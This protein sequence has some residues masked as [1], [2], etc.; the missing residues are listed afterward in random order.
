MWGVP[1][2]RSESRDP[3][4]MWGPKRAYRVEGPGSYVGVPRLGALARD[5][6][7]GGD[8]TGAP[9]LHLRRDD[10]RADAVAFEQGARADRCVT[11][12]ER[13]EADA[14]ERV[15]IDVAL[16]PDRR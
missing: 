13:P 14:I 6:T 16:L 9:A 7:R 2:E 1:S 5:D 12:R 15:V 4:R 11:C 3:L 8:F 10:D